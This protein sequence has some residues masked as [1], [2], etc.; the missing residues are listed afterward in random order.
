DL[1]VEQD[2][3]LHV[4]QI[5]TRFVKHPAD[6]LSVGQK[7]EVKILEVDLKRNRIS[8]SCIKE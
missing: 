4:S 1:G 7:V 8:L 3:L 2:G 5:S 6:V